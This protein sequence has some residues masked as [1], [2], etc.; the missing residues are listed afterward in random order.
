MVIGITNWVPWNQVEQL[1]NPKSHNMKFINFDMW[2]SQL[3]LEKVWQF[4]RYQFAGPRTVSKECVNY[5]LL[6]LLLI[7]LILLLLLLST[8]RGLLLP[9]GTLLPLVLLDSIFVLEII[10]HQPDLFAVEANCHAFLKI[11]QDSPISSKP[12]PASSNIL[13]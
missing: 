11:R 9:E 4:P 2:N 13:R 5:L 1:L 10:G 6:P 7:L 12:F 3:R 8:G